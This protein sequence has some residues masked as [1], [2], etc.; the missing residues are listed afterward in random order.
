MTYEVCSFTGHRQIKAAHR[1]AIDDLV[2]R[3]I[4]FAYSK[5]C[6]IF[7]T[8]G[9]IGF[10]TVAARAVIVFRLSHPD[11]RL[12]CVL[13]CKNQDERWSDRQRDNYEY[14]ISQANEVIYVSDEYTKDCMRRRNSVLAERADILISYVSRNESGAAQ[15]VRMAER[16]GKE[17]YNLYPTLENGKA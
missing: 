4:G 6:R 2:L 16:L 3:A 8:G 13:P 10:D 15:T 7:M 17:I 14:T 12:C 11:V 9:A 5:G 1:K